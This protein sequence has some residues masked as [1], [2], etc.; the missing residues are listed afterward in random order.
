LLKHGSKLK[1]RKKV[2]RSRVYQGEVVKDLFQ[3]YEICGRIFSKRLKPFLTD[4]FSVMEQHQELSL[5]AETKTML[6]SMSRAIID[7]CLS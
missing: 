7:C 1:D 2:G 6:F 4:M 5:S 3:I